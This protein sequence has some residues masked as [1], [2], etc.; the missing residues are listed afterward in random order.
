MSGSNRNQLVVA[1]HRLVVA[2]ERGEQGG[3]VETG[4][5][6]VRPDRDGPV[7][8]HDRGSGAVEGA[9]RGAAVVVCLGDAVIERERAVVDI[10]RLGIAAEVLQDD[11]EIAQRI[12]RLWIDR[13]RRRDQ[14]AGVVVVAL[15]V[16]Q[17]AQ[18][19]Q[20]VEMVR[21]FGEDLRIDRLRRF[22]IARLMELDRL[23]KHR[24]EV[25]RFADP[26]H[27]VII[28][29]SV[30]DTNSAGADDAAT[31]FPRDKWSDRCGKA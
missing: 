7:E 3:P 17:H 28:I 18:E 25:D 23:G 12:H 8:A 19:M 10:E 5:G 15:L 31:C 29:Q 11:A 21:A 6:V 22:E 20:R 27:H 16:A 4:L 1:R 13:N 14:R 2:A 9:Q 26:A 24:S 30:A